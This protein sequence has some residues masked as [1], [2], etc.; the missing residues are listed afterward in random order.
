MGSFIL[1]PM[2]LLM[3]LIVA[4]IVIVVFCAV[5]VPI[6]KKDKDKLEKL[7]AQLPKEKLDKLKNFKFEN[8]ESLGKNMY[9]GI[10]LV[11]DIT[12]NENNVKVILMF[13]NEPRAE[14]YSQTT[15]LTI[16]EY[17]KKNLNQLDYVK[18]VMKYDKDMFIYELKKII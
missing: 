11:A 6:A 7:K 3:F 18:C 13:F 17:S 14:I 16:E 1:S 12:K 5:V 4:L 2:Y 15:K 10:G 9:V 8:D